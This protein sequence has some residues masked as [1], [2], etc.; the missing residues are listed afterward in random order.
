MI[1]L[2]R[3]GC[4]WFSLLLLAGC[5][6]PDWRQPGSSRAVLAVDAADCG[7]SAL[8]AG[9]Q[10]SFSGRHVIGPVFHESYA[11]CLRA[12]GWSP[13]GAEHADSLPATELPVS[14]PPGYALVAESTATHGPLAERTWTLASDEGA[15]TVTSQT[16]SSGTFRDEEYPVPQGL[17]VYDRGR[18]KTPLG[19]A[20]WAVLFGPL[21]E[22][23]ARLQAARGAR[24]RTGKR[25][26]LVWAAAAALPFA[27]G[28]PPA[29][30]ATTANQRQA[31][32]RTRE[33][34][35]NWLA[36]QGRA[37]VE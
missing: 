13:D 23:S 25:T 34:F 31:L 36:R 3:P 5:G 22:D 6:G 35:L 21:P 1:T 18:L 2:K 4:L 26:R 14:P 32:E 11:A 16:L 29:G 27:E 19:P 28:T 8:A 15:L 33:D 10:A 30:L 7:Q 20:R 24:I 37:G 9:R 17:G 12:R